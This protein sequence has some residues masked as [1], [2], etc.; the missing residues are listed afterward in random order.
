M[1]SPMQLIPLLDGLVIHQLLYAAA[2][3]GLA[4]LLETGP[5]STS[6][7]A[8]QLN[9]DE[10]ALYRILRALASKGIFQETAPR[11]FANSELSRYLGAGTAGSMRSLV[12]F[13]GSE[14]FYRCFGEILYCVETGK[15]ARS[16]LIGPSGWEY[17]KGHPD[18][19]RVFDD[20][21]TNLTALAG[22]V[23]A[24]AYDFGRWGSLMD[25]GGGNG[26]FLA[27]I[28]KAYP[29]L[30]GVLAEQPHVLERARERGFLEGELESRTAMQPCD[31]LTEVPTACRAYVLK[32]VI[33]DWDD[34]RAHAILTNCRRV[35]P[36]DGALLLVEPAISDKNPSGKFVD[37]AMLVLTGGKVRTVEEHRGLLAGAGFRVNAVIS[38]PAEYNVV[39]AFP[40]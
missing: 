20:A 34:E 9:V 8:R 40:A 18:L 6:E 26:L 37:I 2:S 12:M 25:V 11:T 38:T 5:L 23:I 30:R 22:P 3:L 31:F 24:S 27:S 19:A 29:E 13:R 14:F 33:C 4:D 21:M 15:S 28:L 10:P 17:M 16:K 39:E 7:M 1:T 32:G 36:E 35:V